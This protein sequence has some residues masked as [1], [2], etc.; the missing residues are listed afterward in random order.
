MKKIFSGVAGNNPKLNRFDL[1]YTN[2]TSMQMGYLYPVQC[3]EVYP[4]DV[5]KMSAFCH[6][7]VMP[8]VAPLMSDIQIFA[9]TFFVPYR[10]IYGIDKSDGK[11]IWEKFITGGQDGDYETPLPSWNPDWI[12]TGFSTKKIWDYIGNPVQ[13]V[14]ITP[15]G[16][17]EEPYKAWQPIVPSGLDVSIAPKYAYNFIYNSFYRD[18]NLIDEVSLDNEDLLLAAFKKDY[19]TSALEQQQRGTAPALPVDITGSASVNYSSLAG[20]NADVTVSSDNHYL[21]LLPTLSDS[22][23]LRL[24]M[25]SNESNTAGSTIDG[26]WWS[27]ISSVVDLSGV[28]ATTFTVSDMRLA[29][30]IQR[31]LELNESAGVRFTEFLSSHYGVSPTD[32]RLDRPEY[33]GGAVMAVSVSPLIQTSETASTPQGN[34]SGVGHVDSIQKIGNYRVL[35]HGLIMTLISIRPKPIYQ[36]GIDRQWLRQ[37]RF[38]YYIPE[39]AYLSEQ[40]VYRCELYVD[41]T[42]ELDSD[43]F[44]YQAHWNEMRCKNNRV[45]GAVREQFDYYATARKFDSRPSLNQDF[46]EIVPSD[47]NKIF[48]VQ[49]ED[50]FIVSWSSIIDAYRPIPAMGVPGLVDHVYGGF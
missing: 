30:A 18:E 3:D 27:G 36:Q 25:G 33:I 5:F 23:K 13:Q 9:H 35:E 4:G 14:T 42:D 43:I 28:S 15:E 2:T 50:N 19:F 17:G 10:L 47:F 24:T 11:P 49:D 45:S 7:E 37:T 1:S 39:L 8:L 41:P 38:D 6:A 22:T 16:E 32:A 31:L 34:K 21:S 12:D 29:F 20:H 46:I 40:G 48:A 44:G 26:T